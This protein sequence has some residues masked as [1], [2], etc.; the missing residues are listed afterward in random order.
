MAERHRTDLLEFQNLPF[1][2]TKLPFAFL[3]EIL[4]IPNG[5]RHNRT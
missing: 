1:L 5:W 3:R 2:I 4:A